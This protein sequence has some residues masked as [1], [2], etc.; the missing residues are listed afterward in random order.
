MKN[1]KTVMLA[2]VFVV[3]IALF[4]ALY[5]TLRPQGTKGSKEFKL[6]VV[7]A[8]G[9]STTHTL[10][11]DAEF[12]GEALLENKLIDGFE[13]EW[14]F[15]ITAVDGVTADESKQEWWQIT[16]DGEFSNYGIDLVPVTDGGHYELTLMVGWE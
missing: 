12:L 9:T 1:K 5:F 7:L 16:I 15:C 11:T 2:T 8:D 13:G 6:E 4:G 3:V 10:R 14:G